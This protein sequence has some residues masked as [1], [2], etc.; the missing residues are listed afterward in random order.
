METTISADKAYLIIDKWFS[1]CAACCENVL[2]IATVLVCPYCHREFAGMCDPYEGERYDLRQTRS[3]LPIVS[4]SAVKE[5]FD[6]L[7]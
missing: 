2:D 6:H 4:Y 7:V 5:V 3:D 1:E